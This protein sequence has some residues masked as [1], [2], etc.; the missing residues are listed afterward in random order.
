MDRWFEISIVI[1]FIFNFIT[2][3]L[4]IHILFI[5]WQ[6]ISWVVP[7]VRPS[8]LPSSNWR[9]PMTFPDGKA[10][11][12]GSKESILIDIEWWRRWLK[13]RNITILYLK[14]IL[15][16]ILQNLNICRF[17]LNFITLWANSAEDKLIFFLVFPYEFWHFIQ[18]ISSKPFIFKKIFQ[19]VCWNF[20]PEAKR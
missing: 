18:I 9:I 19:N 6:R 5:F 12:H 10:L 11:S 17:F 15:T 2:L 14:V 7:P 20:Y 13:V 3:P 4:L 1:I 16:C 8:Y